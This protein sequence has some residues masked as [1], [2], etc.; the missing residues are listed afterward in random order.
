MKYKFRRGLRERKEGWE[1]ELGLS[2]F[3]KKENKLA[4]RTGRDGPVVGIF[5]E[6]KS[7]F[8]ITLRTQI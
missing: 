4:K 5:H 8:I 3:K 6:T 7:F 1:Q 2:T